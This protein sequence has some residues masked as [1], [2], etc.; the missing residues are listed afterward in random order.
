MKSN[1]QKANT[2]DEPIEETEDE[3]PINQASVLV[4]TPQDEDT[5][6][7]NSSRP[8]KGTGDEKIKENRPKKRR[9]REQILEEVKES[10][11]ESLSIGDR[12]ERLPGDIKQPIH[13]ESHPPVVIPTFS[14]PSQP[15]QASK[16]QLALQGMDSAM[17]EAEIVDPATTD[18]L[19]EES[20]VATLLS[21]RMMKRL[22]ELGIVELFAG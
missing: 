17:L 2:E 9:K 22:G 16:T 7:Q 15:P 11:T 3:I 18:R 5:E 10:T 1:K 20:S 4:S 21:S 12:E 14:S 19:G 13:L 8:V 6:M